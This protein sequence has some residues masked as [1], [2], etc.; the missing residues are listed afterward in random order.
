[1]VRIASGYYDGGISESFPTAVT[2]APSAG[3]LVEALNGK[4]KNP[5][6]T[7]MKNIL[8]FPEGKDCLGQGCLEQFQ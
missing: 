3:M 8:G 2:G 7:Q 5:S 4:A 6:G 1:M